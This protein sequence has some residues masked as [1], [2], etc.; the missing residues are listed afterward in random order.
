M[1]GINYLYDISTKI[2]M[3]Y[4]E[5]IKFIRAN[6]PQLDLLAETEVHLFKNESFALECIDSCT[7]LCNT[8]S[9]NLEISVNFAIE[10]NYN[11]NAKAIVKD[12]NGII[13]L[14]LGLIE[15][16]EIIVS[17]SI[18]VFY[19]E[20]ISKLTFSQIDKLEIKNLFSNL[21]ISYLFHH[22]LAHILQ[23]LSLSSE[24]H[25]NLNEEN[26]NKNQFEIKNHIYE[27]DADLFGI[28][29]CTS[30][31]LDYAKNITYPFNT[32]LV[33]NLLTTLLFSISNIIIEF[34][35]NQLADIYYK[36]QSHPH[37]L[38]RIIKCNDQ[39]LS[40]T[41]KNLVIQK[42]FFLAV[43]QRTFKIINQIQYNTKGRIDFSK[44]LHDNISE[45]ELY[46][47]EIEMESEKYNELIRFR[48]QKIFNSLH[49]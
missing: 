28:T 14:N 43:L 3:T 12:N 48:V 37:P 40:F 47:N 30:E 35:K 1:A 10:Y 22:E 25:Y 6:F 18:E 13:L 16:L 5:N 7:K 39:I 21:C 36:K 26:S 31:L 8:A 24:N 23:F 49:E 17:D 2:K 19:L 32:I 33:F 11:F 42:E 34:S 38:I 29:M 15:R 46:I 20:N 44:L 27:M 41:S 9:R 45:I 4:G